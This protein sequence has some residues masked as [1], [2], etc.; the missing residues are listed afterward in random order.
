VNLNEKFQGCGIRTFPIGGVLDAPTQRAGT[1]VTSAVLTN[2]VYV[3]K[4]IR[5]AFSFFDWYLILKICL[6]KF[7]V[8]ESKRPWL[9]RES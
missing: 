4:V 7:Y 3:S 1:P 8:T 9:I 5:L 2:L 6:R